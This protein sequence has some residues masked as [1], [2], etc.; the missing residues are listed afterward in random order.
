M[1]SILFITG[2]LESRILVPLCYQAVHQYHQ[3]TTIGGQ[4]DP[5]KYYAIRQLN[6][7]NYLYI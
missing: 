4:C 7:F 1:I 5:V 2:D 3:E 6:I